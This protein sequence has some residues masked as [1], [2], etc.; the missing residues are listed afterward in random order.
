M[1]QLELKFPQLL[2]PDGK[3]IL[4]VPLCPWLFGSV[5]QSVGRVKRY[6]KCEILALLDQSGYR[7]L[8]YRSFHTLATPGLF[9]NSKLLHRS[10][11]GKFQLKLHHSLVPLFALMETF[12]PFPRA[13]A[14]IVAVPK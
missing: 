6:S 13:N 14:L 2:A 12:L 4:T 1:I 10:K 11:L 8:E 9:I 7:I 3:L 5:D